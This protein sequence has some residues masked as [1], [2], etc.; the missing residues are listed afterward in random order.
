MQA[1]MGYGHT[2]AATNTQQNLAY[3][4]DNLGNIKTITDT[5][6]TGSRSFDYDDLNRLTQ[7]TG[8]FGGTTQTQVSKTTATTPSAIS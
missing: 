7:A 8:T 5:I 3:T 4:Y 1:L 6:W 2:S